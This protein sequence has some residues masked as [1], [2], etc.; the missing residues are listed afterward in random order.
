MDLSARA[1]HLAKLME[2][3]LDV[4]GQGLAVKLG[5]V[6][7]RLPKA[8]HHDIEFILQ[9]CHMANNPKLAPQIDWVQLETRFARAEK[10]IASVSPWKRRQTLALQWLAGNLLN[11][12]LIGALFLAAVISLGLV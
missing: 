9:A 12:L 3:H 10:Y 8:Y 11:L 4:M 5:R 2:E 1:D 6:G 7:K